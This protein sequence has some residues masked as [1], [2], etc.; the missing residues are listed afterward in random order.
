MGS[1]GWALPLVARMDSLSSSWNSFGVGVGANDGPDVKDIENPPAPAPQLS[2]VFSRPDWPSGR[3]GSY[4]RDIQAAD[5]RA[6][7]WNV[8][9][10]TPEANSE[11]TLAWPEINRVP[12]GYDLY[13]TDKAT[14]QRRSMRQTSSIRV[15]TGSASTRAFVVSAEPRRLGSL[16]VSSVIVRSVGRGNSAAISFIASQDANVQVRI[17]KAGGGLLRNLATRSASA[18]ETTVTW[19]L[20]DNRGVSVPS[21]AYTIEVKAATTDGQSAR[22]IAPYLVVR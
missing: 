6:K 1:S 10:T 11:I 7:T 13:I 5:G 22:Q 21:G 2:V 3:A 18:G 8:I 4:M 16:T 17:L 9:V 14:G 12:R 15:N 20:K 19:D